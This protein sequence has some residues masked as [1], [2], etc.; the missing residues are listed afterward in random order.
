MLDSTSVLLEATAEATF[1]QIATALDAAPVLAALLAGS[2]GTGGI[3]SAFVAAAHLQGTA[4]RYSICAPAPASLVVIAPRLQHQLSAI[5]SNFGFNVSDLARVLRVQRPTIYAWGNDDATPHP[6]NMQRIREVYDLSRKWRLAIGNNVGGARQQ[7]DDKF[8]VLDILQ[9][10][11]LREAERALLAVANRRAV[12]PARYKSVME[13]G[14]EFG[15][16]DVP[17]KRQAS[18][19]RDAGW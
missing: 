10:D 15:F 5:R 12:A 13:L 19:L 8:T 2:V 9:Q 16:N 18:S 1:A 17:A 4:A 3:T 6:S 11:D 14:E 7:Y